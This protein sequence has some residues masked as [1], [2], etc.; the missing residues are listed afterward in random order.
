MQDGFTFVFSLIS[1]LPVDTLHFYFCLAGW[2][3][4][5]SGVF[6]GS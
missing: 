3:G 4:T 5:D 6:N 2:P 1:V